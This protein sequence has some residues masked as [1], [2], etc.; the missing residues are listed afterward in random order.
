[1]DPLRLATQ[2]YQTA[3][4][5]LFTFE[6]F[7][8]VIDTSQGSIYPADL[9]AYGVVAALIVATGLAAAFVPARR[10]ARVDPLAIVVK[11]N[12]TSGWHFC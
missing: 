8:C 5:H 3:P 12:A 6:R 10:A 2:L 9:R 4:I 1:M 11:S 7:A